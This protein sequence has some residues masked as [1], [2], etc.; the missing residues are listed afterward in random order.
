MKIITDKKS[1]NKKK[2]DRQK[3]TNDIVKPKMRKI[4]DKKEREKRERK[5]KSVKENVRKI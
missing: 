5:R 2:W 3:G 1:D 4:K